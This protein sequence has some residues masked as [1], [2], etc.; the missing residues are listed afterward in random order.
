MMKIFTF[1]PHSLIEL[2]NNLSDSEKGLSALVKK[3]TK[4][5]LGTKC[6]VIR[7]CSLITALVPGVSTRLRPYKNVKIFLRNV[8]YT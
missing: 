2:K 6:S 4:S 3:M 7:W 1:F 8:T 5:L